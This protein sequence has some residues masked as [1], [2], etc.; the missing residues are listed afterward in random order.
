MASIFLREETRLLARQI[1]NEAEIAN[2][3][4][5]RIYLPF[6][7]EDNRLIIGRPRRVHYYNNDMSD[8]LRG[9]CSLF[10]SLNYDMTAR[11]KRLSNEK[12]N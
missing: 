12:A 6:R 1:R 3:L 4:D 10:L 5:G 2:L 9:E 7:L 8:I 11:R